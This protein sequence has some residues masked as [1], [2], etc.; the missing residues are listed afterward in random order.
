M[1]I[2]QINFSAN[3]NPNRIPR[4]N[5]NYEQKPKHLATKNAQYPQVNKPVQS[6]NVPLQQY[7]KPHINQPTQPQN[8]PTQQY[9]PN[10]ICVPA[11]QRAEFDLTQNI[12]P[13]S[14]LYID[15][16]NFSKI[17]S[18]PTS[19]VE[20]DEELIAQRMQVVEI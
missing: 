19:R 6:Q 4:N 12:P 8:M 15:A 18:A 14:Q 10:A 17:S 16:D 5:R 2:S 11:R 7:Q 3:I 1:A 20:R 9:N 13:R